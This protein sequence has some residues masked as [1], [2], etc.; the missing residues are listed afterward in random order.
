MEPENSKVQLIIEGKVQKVGYRWFA[1][2]SARDL[3][4]RGF[5]QNQPDGTVL[6]EAEGEKDN[7]NTLTD[8]LKHGPFLSKVTKINIEWRQFENE[9]SAFDIKY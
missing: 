1:V 2:K 8:K 6:L 4:L 3:G 5:A 7:I 9:F